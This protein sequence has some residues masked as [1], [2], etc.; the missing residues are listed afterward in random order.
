M[1]SQYAAGRVSSRIARAMSA[2]IIS[3]RLS[4]RWSTQVPMNSDA[5][6]GSQT[7]AVRKPT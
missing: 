3:R 5:M 7:A 1:S 6:F 4:G 2:A